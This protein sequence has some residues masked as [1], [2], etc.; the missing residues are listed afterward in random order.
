MKRKGKTWTESEDKYLIDNFYTKTLPELANYFNI[1]VYAIRYRARVLKL[2]HVKSYEKVKV[3]DKFGDLTI[4]NKNTKRGKWYVEC[5]CLCGTIT[6]VQITHLISGT[7]KGCGCKASRIL[8]EMPGL[9][10]Y[11][12]KH[13]A[14]IKN[15]LDYG[16][17]FSLTL[18]EFISLITLNC[19]YCNEKPKFHNM[20]LNK[21][22]KIHKGY[23][24]KSNLAIE[25]ANVYVNGIDRLDSTKGYSIE[26]CVP[27]CWPCNNFKLGRNKEEFL[28]II[29]KIYSYRIILKN[30]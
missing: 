24:T 29:E 8:S 3:G 18:E 27:C 13:R 11:K 20:Y 1:G 12:A 14:Y 2:K 16:R 6:I 5:T 21:E 10:S 15:A 19:Y 30:S 23:E 17:E 7:V 26:N 28:E 4:S 9:A 22:G 25:A